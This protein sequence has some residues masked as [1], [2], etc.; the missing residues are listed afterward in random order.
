MSFRVRSD[1]FSKA[2]IDGGSIAPVRLEKARRNVTNFVAQYLRRTSP[3]SMIVEDDFPLIATATFYEPTGHGLVITIRPKYEDGNPFRLRTKN[4]AANIYGD[5]W[6]VHRSYYS[7]L[8]PRPH[9][10]ALK[11]WPASLCCPSPWTKSTRTWL[12]HS[13]PMVGQSTPLLDYFDE[14]S[15]RPFVIKIGHKENG[16]FGVT[17][18]TIRE[19]LR[20]QIDMGDPIFLVE[21]T[22]ETVLLLWLN[23]FLFLIVGLIRD[24]H[25]SVF[26][27]EFRQCGEWAPSRKHFARQE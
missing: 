11:L 22:C 23:S 4:L 2:K 10:Q 15:L 21:F 20:K 14:L 3:A 5:V 18:A 7:H 13:W 24:L 25:S 26:N 12:I 19:Q 17:H 6:K 16:T 8:M 1:L 27:S 9:R